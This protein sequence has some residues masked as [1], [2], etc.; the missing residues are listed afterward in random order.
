MGTEGGNFKNAKGTKDVL[1]K[2]KL[3][4]GVFSGYMDTLCKGRLQITFK[5]NTNDDMA[6][7]V[8]DNGKPGKV[9]IKSMY[10][11][12]RMPI[13]KYDPLVEVKLKAD[14]VKQPAPI[15]F[16][17]S[18]TVKR[19]ISGSYS[20]IDLT[21]SC[22]FDM[23]EWTIFLFQTDRNNANQKNYSAK[24]DH[25]NLKNAYFENGR[26]ETFSSSLQNLNISKNEY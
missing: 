3:L 14:L 2:L 8:W 12:R 6:V 24:C 23:P 1:F 11:T 25:C 10:I 20:E 19:L 15:E 4:G 18:Q 26:N 16:I 13:V 17:K 7:H 9:E 5:R 21:N 22:Q